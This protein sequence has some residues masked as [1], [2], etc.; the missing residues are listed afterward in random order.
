MFARV[1]PDLEEL[2]IGAMWVDPLFR[3]LGMAA[4]ML[5]GAAGWARREGATRAE[6]WVTEGNTAA[7]TLYETAG[8]L[9][10]S[11]TKP[12][13]DGAPHQIRKLIANL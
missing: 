12:L 3:R 8:F 7:S 4:R 5:D 6:L 2:G 11:E 13:R 1:S 10:T 9:P